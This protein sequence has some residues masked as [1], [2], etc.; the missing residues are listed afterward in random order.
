MER[1]CTALPLQQR[2]IVTDAGQ[3]NYGCGSC[4]MNQ[5]CE[6]RRAAGLPGLSIAWGPVA[7]VGYVAEQERLVR[8][9]S[10]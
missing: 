6:M 10:A 7:H 4:A 2:L 5:L 3:S 8:V 1:P 9:H